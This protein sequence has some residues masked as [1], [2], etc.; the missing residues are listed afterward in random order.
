MAILVTN[1]LVVVNVEWRCHIDFQHLIGTILN[2]LIQ[3]NGAM[4]QGMTIHY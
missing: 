3:C 4:G 1:Y 2:T